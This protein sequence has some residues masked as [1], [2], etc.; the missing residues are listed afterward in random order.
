MYK[1]YKGITLNN[2]KLTE[3]MIKFYIGFFISDVIVWL[4]LD[5]YNGLNLFFI[6]IMI[7]LVLIN[8][9]WIFYMKQ[10]LKVS[11]RLDQIGI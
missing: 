10:Y 2:F 11:K 4:I 9:L 7:I 6:P 5:I 8:G 1:I 3:K